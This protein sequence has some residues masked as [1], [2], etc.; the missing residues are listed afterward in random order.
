MDKNSLK[1][2]GGAPA[3]YSFP[4]PENKDKKETDITVR[5]KIFPEQ[6]PPSIIKILLTFDHISD[7]V[8]WK[9]LSCLKFGNQP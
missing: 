1:N 5:H 4:I 2:G 7:S 3:E 9:T 8:D 6:Y